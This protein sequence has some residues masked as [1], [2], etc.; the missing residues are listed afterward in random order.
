MVATTIQCVDVMKKAS[1]LQKHKST[2]KVFNKIFAY[3]YYLR[4]LLK[5]FNKLM[6]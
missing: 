4:N 5:I 6:L 1:N 3:C 2:N